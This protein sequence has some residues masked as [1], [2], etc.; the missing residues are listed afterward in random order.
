VTARKQEALSSNP[1]ATKKEKKSK[2]L[3]YFNK[4][5]TLKTSYQIWSK[6]PVTH[7][8]NPSYTAGRNQKQ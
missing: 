7:T 1:R 3:V 8:C 2:R 6:A 5:F 4:V